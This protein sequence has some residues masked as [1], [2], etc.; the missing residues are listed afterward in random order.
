MMR[1]LLITLD[2]DYDNSLALDYLVAYARRDPVLR[3]QVEFRELIETAPAEESIRSALQE[4]WDIVG[5]NTYV[6]NLS[7][8]LGLAARFKMANSDTSV[9][10]GGMEASYTAGGLLDANRHVDFVVLGE[11]EIAFAELLRRLLR[12][13]PVSGVI[14]GI[15]YRGP[16]GPVSGGQGPVVSTL[17]DIPSPFASPAFLSR[18]RKRILYE[19][20]RGCA[21]KCGFCLYHRD[22]T[23]QRAFSLERIASD[24]QAIKR[25]GCSH[26]RF[27]DSTF[28]LDR[29]RAKSI[30]RLL[31]DMRVEVSVEVSAEFFDAEMI[32]MFPKAGIRQVDI[33]LQSTNSAA[34]A[35]VN[36]KWYRED[37][38]RDNLRLLRGQA[39]LTL[40]V[41]LIAGLPSDDYSGL[42]NS[43][44][45]AVR[46]W[47]DHVSV[48]RLLGLRGTDVER[49]KDELGLRFSDAPPYEVI[50]SPGFSEEEL[51]GIDI[52]AF[53]HLMLFNLGIGRYALRY[54]VERAKVSPTELY[55]AF[56]DFAINK[57]GPY[58]PDEAAMLGRLY[59]HGNRFD[60]KLPSGLSPERVLAAL[61]EFYRCACATLDSGEF[62]LVA[63]L[64]DYGYRLA[65]L[66]QFEGMA[67]ATDA[68]GMAK[69]LRLSPWC[70]MQ[71]Y[72]RA[73]YR[74][75]Q[76]QDSEN[77]IL[78][79]HEIGGVVFFNHPTLGPASVAV[80]TDVAQLIE[81]MKRQD[82]A[83]AL[84]P[85]DGGACAQADD[86][87]VIVSTLR[88]FRILLPAV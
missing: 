66:D 75:L 49:R 88:E 27:V 54:V 69:G 32:D 84:L 71:S 33:G 25:S 6:W 64:L 19:S 61:T 42:K 52:L 79:P 35:T 14:P 86:E 60:R 22:Y 56:I 48:Y 23:K 38:F 50:A 55:E 29:C 1:V 78:E 46:L 31:A 34:L 24:L 67:S 58:R 28:N 15:A 73:V 83:E 82:V 68:G 70:D 51:A 30:L 43:I 11:G 3:D 13:E 74:E 81:S 41:E 18:P 21:F 12:R 36:R 59:A 37:R 40:N 7:A 77:E 9:V 44:D 57:D 63:P 26:I 80:T 65:L 5:F 85:T 2:S 53:A 45:E 16:L 62:R 17:D 76:R 39:G 8:N 47:P 4:H 87:A 10:F 72:S 20:Y